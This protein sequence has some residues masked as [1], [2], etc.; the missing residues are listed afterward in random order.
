MK[1]VLMLTMILAIISGCTR[2][3]YLPI[4]P[5]SPAEL[6]ALSLDGTWNVTKVDYS[7]ALAIPILGEITAEGTAEDVGIFS[8]NNEEKTC[9]Y[10]INFTTEPIVV[11]GFPIPGL[12]V[13]LSGNGTWENTTAYVIIT[14]ENGEDAIFK[15]IT[16]EESNK[17]MTGTLPYTYLGQTVDVDVTLTLEK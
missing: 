1:K 7:T 16:D 8:F 12:P 15:V 14:L 6:F 13:D 17:V 9:L 2:D 5:L 11:G 10:N 3:T 4:D